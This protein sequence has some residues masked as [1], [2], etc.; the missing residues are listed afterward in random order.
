M[1]DLREEAK[2]ILHKHYMEKSASHMLSELLALIHAD[3]GHYETEHGTKKAVND[4][5]D[6][7]LNERCGA[8]ENRKEM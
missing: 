8:L 5:M 6:K 2:A 4:A 7:I 3:G 1:S